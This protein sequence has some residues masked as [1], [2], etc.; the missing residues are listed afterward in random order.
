MKKL[1][2]IVLPLLFFFAIS[3]TQ[4]AVSN[5]DRAT[6]SS[7]PNTD[8]A[9]KSDNAFIVSKNWIDT[10]LNKYVLFSNNE[11]VRAAVNDKISEEWL[12][13]QFL[14]ADTTKY[15]IY[16]IGHDVTDEDGANP[17]F[18]TDQWVYVDTV[19]RILY[20]YDLPND[21]LIRWSK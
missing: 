18:V 14:N 11:L 16:Q 5:S 9:A 15:F 17:R 8:S 7:L 10:L 2:C 4:R 20:E 12:F 19:R 6:I 13:D 3:C 1:G 21:S